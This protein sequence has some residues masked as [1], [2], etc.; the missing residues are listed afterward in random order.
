MTRVLGTVEHDR[1]VRTVGP[2]RD[3]L[4]AKGARVSRTEALHRSEGDAQKNTSFYQYAHCS[5]CGS[6][7]RRIYFEEPACRAYLLAGEHIAPRTKEGVQ[8]RSRR[9]LNEEL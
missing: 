2:A 7:V 3:Q 5:R 9:R 8:M 4:G 6:E 1:G